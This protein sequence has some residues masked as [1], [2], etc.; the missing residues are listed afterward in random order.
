MEGV[1]ASLDRLGWARCNLRGLWKVDCEDYISALAHNLSKA[2]RKLG[3][4]GPPSPA[5]S[6]ERAVTMP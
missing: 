2:M 6:G 1:F 5:I 3:G 4:V